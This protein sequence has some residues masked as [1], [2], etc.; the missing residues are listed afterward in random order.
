[1]DTGPNLKDIANAVGVSSATVSLYL[2]DPSTH[3]VGKKTKEHIDEAMQDLGYRPN[4]FAR[5]LASGSSHIIGIIKPT[6][7]PIFSNCFN[8]VIIAG[9][10]DALSVDHYSLLF[11]PS[12]GST[13][14]EVVKFQIYQGYGCDGYILFGSRFCSQQDIEKNIKTLQH[15]G[16]PFVTVNIPEMPGDIA[17]IIVPELSSISGINYLFERGHR[18]VLLLLGRKEGIFTKKILSAYVLLLKK[19]DIPYRKEN[20]LYGDYSKTEA[21]QAVKTRIDHG[22][23]NFTALCSMSDYMAVGAYE[24]LRETGLSI[25]EDISV[26]GRN[27]SDFSTALSPTLTTVELQMEKIGSEAAKLLHRLIKGDNHERI[28][29]E[30]KLI[31]RNSVYPLKA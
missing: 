21:Y 11:F 17:Q 16:K 12:S 4:L 22:P 10:Q 15:T 25:P 26:V 3:R 5:S 24:A 28:Y 18:Q 31:I 27:N 23:Q 2:N 20:V 1:M 30:S 6:L 13:S 8:N 9:I 29:L 14:S 7:R 19:Y